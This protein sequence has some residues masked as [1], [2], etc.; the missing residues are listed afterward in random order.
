MLGFFNINKYLRISTIRKII[1]EVE[2]E[3]NEAKYDSMV[4]MEQPT[5]VL[6]SN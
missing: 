6:R 2:H 3:V 5:G 1:D 4:D